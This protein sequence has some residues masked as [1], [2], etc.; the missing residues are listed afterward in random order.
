MVNWQWK[1]AMT[2]LSKHALSFL[3]FRFASWRQSFSGPI[4][5]ELD[6]PYARTDALGADLLAGHRSSDGLGILRE[7]Q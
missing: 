6:H 5:E 2:A 3:Q 4:D 7:K 1:T